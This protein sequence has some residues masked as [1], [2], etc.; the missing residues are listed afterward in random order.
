MKYYLWSQGDKEA[1]D[2]I[3]QAAQKCK[4]KWAFMKLRSAR[5]HLIERRTT[6]VD[7]DDYKGESFVTY[8]EAI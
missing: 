2:I 8:R 3:R 4:Y 1:N 7:D 5:F 6:M